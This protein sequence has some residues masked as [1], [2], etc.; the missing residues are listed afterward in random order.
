MVSFTTP[1]TGIPMINTV[2]A[3]RL[4]KLGI[5]TVAD[6]LLHIPSRYEDYSQISKI[7][8][9]QA[10]E[11]ITIIGTISDFKNIYTKNGK[12][13][14]KAKVADETGEVDTVW[15]NQPFLATVLKKGSAVGISGEVQWF[16]NKLTFQSPEY[17]IIRPKTND[18]RLTTNLIHTGRLVPV[19]PE[20]YGISSKWLRSRIS[21]VLSHIGEMPPDTLPVPFR[22]KWH[23]VSY[24]EAVLTIH[25]PQSL[26]SAALA[27]QRLAFDELLTLQLAARIRKKQWQENKTAPAFPIKREQGKLDAFIHT[28]PFSLTGAQNRAVREILADLTKPVPMNR[29]LEGDVGSGKTVVAAVAMYACFLGGFR[30]AF[31]A[32]TEILAQQHYETIQRLLSPMGI[33]VELVTGNTKKDKALKTKDQRPTTKDKRLKTKLPD[34]YVGTHALLSRHVLFKKMGLMVIDEQQRFGVSQRTQ[35]R[36]KGNSPHLLS[37]TATP[38]PRTIALTLYADLDLSVLD[39][40]PKGRRI[41]KTWVVGEE[42]RDSGYGWMRTLLRE[43]KGQAFIICPLIE[44]SESLKT[45]KNA[46]AEF[47][48]L[49]K[50]IFPDFSLALLHGRMKPGEKKS[51]LDEFRN[52]KHAILVATPVVE[53][54]IDIPNAIIIVI[55]AADRFGLSQL[56]QLRGRVGRGDLQSYCLLFTQNTSE[57]TL[58]RLKSLETTH[59]GPQLAEIDLKLRGAGDIYGTRQHGMPALKIASMFDRALMEKSKRAANELT[60]LDDALSSFPLLLERVQRYTIEEVAPD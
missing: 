15:Y 34:I 48:H 41:V 2:Y 39:E 56:H 49:S 25:F 3:G 23:L 1:V 58:E 4:K 7:N 35:F 6:L 57:K 11:R 5:E 38:I 17:E 33:T 50:D 29:L 14:Q 26:E 45:V 54:G 19:Y 55:E 44:E 36:T 9:L 46:T 12:K 43:K 20:T 27:R 40:M 13:I 60:A 31:M 42:K 51:V 22:K 53:V 10:G 47:T 32:P 59:V 24:E 30:S 21:F 28:L 18:Q 16:G 37:M 52:Q 8:L